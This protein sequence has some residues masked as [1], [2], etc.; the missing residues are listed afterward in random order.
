[1]VS[2]FPIVGVGA[3]AGGVEALEALFRPMP[4]EPGMAFVV[5][6]HLGPKYESKLAKILAHFTGV[7]VHP[8][9][10]RDAIA[11]NL[12]Y[13]LPRQAGLTVASGLCT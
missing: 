7:P 2:S 1:M 5:V 10:D 12:I 13:V 11:R 4:A 9:C 3:S 6:T 8:I